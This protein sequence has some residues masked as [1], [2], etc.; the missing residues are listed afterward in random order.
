MMKLAKA[1]EKYFTG[2]AT[3]QGKLWVH[4]VYNP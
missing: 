2:H 3:V 1:E 4:S